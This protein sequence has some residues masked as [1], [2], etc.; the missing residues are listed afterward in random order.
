[1]KY[2]QLSVIVAF[3]LLMISCERNLPS[4]LEDD[5]VFRRDMRTLVINIAQ[6]ARAADG[7]FLIVPQNGQGVVLT[8]FCND[9][10]N[11]VDQAYM[12]SVSAIGREDLHY[13]Y[14]GD[15]MLNTVSEEQEVGAFLKLYTEAGKPVLVTD[16][17]S[18]PSLMDDAYRQSEEDGFI[19]FAAPSRE[20]D[21]IPGYPSKPYNVHNNDVRSM[22]DV[23]NFLYLLNADKFSGRQAYLQSLANT[24][25]DLL[26][27]DAFYKGQLLSAAEVNALKT[28]AG[29]GKRLVIAYMSIGEAEDYRFYWQNSWNQ[30]PP[31]WVETENPDWPGNYKIEYWDNQWHNLIYGDPD[32]YLNKILSSGFDGAYLD[33]IDAYE[34]FED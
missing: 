4:V 16:Y 13:G 30:E 5:Y 11:S 7:D 15:N 20:L 8:G 21:V 28:K 23:Q 19:G 10:S 3:S 27:I 6:K 26:I 18:D 14:S 12:N 33:L 32:S 29:G 24:D 2:F 17:C 25:Y 34:Y 9:C 31:E 22:T 1:M